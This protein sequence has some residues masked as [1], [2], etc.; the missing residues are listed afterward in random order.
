[1]YIYRADL[2]DLL[3][4]LSGYATVVKPQNVHVGLPPTFAGYVLSVV[5]RRAFC[6]YWKQR[7]PLVA[8]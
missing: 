5:Q 4:F 1:M 2:S 3:S 8:I 6:L 7:C